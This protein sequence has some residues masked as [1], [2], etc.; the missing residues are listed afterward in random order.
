MNYDNLLSNGDRLLKED[1]LFDLLLLGKTECYKTK[2]YFID[3][4][5][6]TINKN[7]TILI[8]D[9]L[10]KKGKIVKTKSIE[11]V[12]MF[13][14]AIQELYKKSKPKE[15]KKL[16]LLIKLLPMINLKYNIVCKNPSEEN[17]ENVEPYK[18][19]ELCELLGYEKSN[20]SKLKR[21]LFKLTINDELVIGI[22]EKVN[23]KAIYVNPLL[24]YKG[25]RLEDIN[26]LITMFKV[27]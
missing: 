5:L 1:D 21:D 19:P 17:I 22:F 23:G 14:D 27:N 7:K 18:M 4:E 15:H 3:N 6:I 25:T 24:Y 20:A 8:N 9:K 16:A 12:R 13:N 2:K 11:V 26:S 10:C